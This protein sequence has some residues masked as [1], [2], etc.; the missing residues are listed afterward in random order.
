MAFMCEIPDQNVKKFLE[1]CSTTLILGDGLS[2]LMSAQLI[3]NLIVIYS[4][5]FSYKPQTSQLYLQASEYVYV[6]LIF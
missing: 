6:C 2:T 1:V 3:I 4:Q 5:D